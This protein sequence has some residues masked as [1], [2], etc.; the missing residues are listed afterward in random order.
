MSTSIAEQIQHLAENYRWAWHTPTQ[1]LFAAAA[2]SAFGRFR[3]NPYAWLR[4][5]GVEEAARRITDGGLREELQSVY[6]DFRTYMDAPHSSAPPVAYFCFEYGLHETLPIYAGGLGILAGDHVKEASDQGIDF[7]ALGFLYPDGYLAQGVDARGQQLSDSAQLERRDHPLTKVDL[8]LAVT[9]PGGVVFADVYELKV[10]RSRLFLLDTEI[11]RNTDPNLRSLCR[12]LYGGNS[13]TRLR[14]ELLLGVGGVRLLNHL[15]LL[16]RVLHLNEGHCAFA[17]AEAVRLKEPGLGGRDAAIAHIKS[18][19]VFT[20]HTPVPAGHDR[21]DAQLAGEHLAA[22]FNGDER[23]IEWVRDQGWEE[24]TQRGAICMTVLALNL[25]G[26]C[27]GVSA[28]HGRVSR[29]MWGREIGHVTNGVHVPSWVAHEIRTRAQDESLWEIRRQLRTR[30]VSKVRAKLFALSPAVRTGTPE[31]LS[32]DVLTVGFARRFAPYK[33]ATLLLEQRDRLAR[34]LNNPDRPVQIL[35]AGKAHPADRTGQE[36]MR[37]IVEAARDEKLGGRIHF[38]PDYDMEVGRLLVQGC[39]VWL[40]TPRRPL[41]ASGTSGQKAA[42]NGGLNL[43]VPDGWWP[44]GYDGE[45]G[46]VIA[47]DIGEVDASKQDEADIESVLHQLEHVV[48]P[49][50]YDQD[51]NG[52]S[53]SWLARMERSID[54]ITPHFSAERMLQDYVADYYRPA[55]K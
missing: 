53:A 10:G 28:I 23:F 3:G 42:M 48:A 39:D 51:A 17:L 44:E 33:R 31:R 13:T 1:R 8:T 5:V 24:G 40:N 2:G 30:L 9:M 43:S 14:Q 36:L 38:V 55:W 45:N 6:D 54:T 52:V 12:R 27:N 11:D 4:R 18:T 29:N 7:I 26:S 25:S 37:L 34:I 20:T 50:F 16:D 35:Y 15:G 19:S 22:T 21:F 41:E 49:A 32:P 46:W 47:P